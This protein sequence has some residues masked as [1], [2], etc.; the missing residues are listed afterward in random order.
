MQEEVEFADRA[1]LVQ[2]AVLG[3][4][5]GLPVGT[6]RE[7]IRRMMLRQDY[8]VNF[9]F[10]LHRALSQ[11]LRVCPP[12]DGT[13]DWVQARDAEE[14]VWRRIMGMEDQDP[15]VRELR[16]IISA[17]LQR[18]EESLREV[19]SALSHHSK[20]GRGRRQLADQAHITLFHLLLQEFALV[21]TLGDLDLRPGNLG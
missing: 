3:A 11:A 1:M 16:S 21:P 20:K 4:M 8:L 17:R 18:R 2:Q 15:M 12:G 9:Q 13:I 10:W 7:V 6:A 5:R 19:E 14:H